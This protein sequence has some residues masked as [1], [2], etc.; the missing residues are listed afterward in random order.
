VAIGENGEVLGRV[1]TLFTLGGTGE[2]SDGQLLERFATGRGEAAELAF[3]ALVERHGPMVLRVC[4]GVLRDSHEADDAFQATFLVLVRRARSLWVRD[5]LGPWLHQVAYRTASCLR[6]GAARRRRLER[7]VAGSRGED[8]AGTGHELTAVLHEELGRLPERYRAPAVL[9]DLEGSSHEQAARHLGWPIG[10]V[11]SRLT[12]AREILRDRLRRR[13][14][15]PDAGLLAAALRPI[16]ALLPPALVDSTT[17]AV[18]LFVTSR[19]IP[20]GSA[21]SL[22]REVLRAMSVTRWMKAASML[23][24]AAATV[25]GAASL[26]QG[27]GADASPRAVRA[28]D[29]PAREVRPGKLRVAV[30]ER[31][32]VEALRRDDVLSEIEGNTTILSIRPEGSRV[33]KGDVVGELDSAT[34]RD[35]LKNQQITIAQAEANFRNAGIEREI[36]ELALRESEGA[37]K[38]EQ[39]ALRGTIATSRSTI[40]KAEARLERTRRARKRLDEAVAARKGEAAPADIVA[41]LDIDERL[42]NAGQLISRE[43]VAL[44][45]AETRLDVL[46]RYTIDRTKKERAIDIERKRSSELARKAAS[47]LERDKAAKLERQIKSCTLI[48]PG[49][50]IIVY[51][52]DPRPRGG[53]MGVQIEEGAT[54]RER[55]K[56]FSVVDVDGPMRVNAKVKEGMVDRVPPGGRAR[57]KVDAFANESLTGVVTSVAPRPDP[58]TFFGSDIKVYTTLVRIDKPLRGLRPGMTAEV[59]IPIV[60]LDDVLTVPVVA[61]LQFDD[62]D[63]VAVKKPGGGSEFREVALGESDGESVEVRQGLRSGE[64][65]ILDPA[66][67][68]T[69]AERRAKLA[70]PTKPAARAKGRPMPRDQ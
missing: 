58:N 29:L 23:A 45:V 64:S 13:G 53:G 67:L 68:M 11:K 52:N 44:E 42:E 69:D 41:E 2:L 50:G 57:I 30:V 37:I 70:V 54:V 1:R 48:A 25:T 32:S 18:V 27:P 28:D 47:A 6:T 66:A 59:E 34:L 3:A 56:I 16:Q 43:R 12:R 38:A 14:F 19:A 24:V 39:E 35:N 65:V 60:E 31:G 61:V 33:K 26:A 15:G 46:Q 5:S 55:Q 40:E 63:H 7:G 51:A 10:T 4:R 8:R 49:D 9:C 62:K 20:P 36:A 22:A 21:A 17:R